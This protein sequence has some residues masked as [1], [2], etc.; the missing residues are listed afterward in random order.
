LNLNDANKQLN[1][2]A[3]T[4]YTCKYTVELKT[5]Q[6]AAVFIKCNPGAFRNMSARESV[7]DN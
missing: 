6:A 7:E 3:F 1:L 2:T 5:S 4:S